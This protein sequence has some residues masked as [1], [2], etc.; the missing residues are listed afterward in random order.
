VGSKC[1]DTGPYISWDRKVEVAMNDKY[2]TD[3][4]NDDKPSGVGQLKW[5]LMNVKWLNLIYCCFYH[6]S[7]E[8]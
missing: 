5:I 1:W 3:N 7:V 8:M 2:K 4:E 6:V